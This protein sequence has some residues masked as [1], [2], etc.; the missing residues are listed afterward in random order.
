V[1][2]LI[3]ALMPIIGR[4]RRERRG[5]WLLIW[6]AATVVV[7]TFVPMKKNAYLLPAMPAQTLLTAAALAAMVRVP[8][9]AKNAKTEAFVLAAYLVAGMVVLGV[10][11]YLAA[12]IE[13]FEIDAPAPLLAGAGL[14]A[15]LLLCI[16]QIAPV[17][18]SPRTLLTTAAMFALAVHLLTAWVMPNRDNQR[19]D[20]NLAL[21]ARQA[22]DN[23][24]PVV[25]IGPGLRE[26]VVFYLG[27]TVP[28][29]G[30]IEQLPADFKGVAIVTPEQFLPVNRSDRGDEGT[31]SLNRPAK[32]TIRLFTFPKAPKQ[33]DR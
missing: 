30:S 1:I 7:F 13:R 32:D 11:V 18:R 10:A 26:D 22:M 33:V 28:R 8:R 3:G 31:A 15:L 4:G 9:A 25:L 2:T 23:G 14:V 6:L 12:S 17:F 5:T 19:S 24:V 27:R 16:R 20:Q 29:I 21:S